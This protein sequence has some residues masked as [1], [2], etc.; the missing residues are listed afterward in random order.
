[1]AFCWLQWWLKKTKLLGAVTNVPSNCDI[2]PRTATYCNTLRH[3]ATHCYIPQHTVIHRN[4]LHHTATHCDTLQHTA[5]QCYILQH[6][7]ALCNAL[8]HTSPICAR[9]CCKKKN[10]KWNTLQPMVTRRNVLHR[11]IIHEHY[12]SLILLPKTTSNCN[13]LQ[14]TATHCNTLHHIAA[15][16]CTVQ[17]VATHELYFVLV[18]SQTHC[19]TLQHTA[20]Y[21]ST[22]G[23]GLGSRP[24]KMYG[25]RLG[26]GVEYHLMSPTPRR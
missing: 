25:E 20:P 19:N 10:L 15:H 12:F 3:T 16:C 6:T 21:C 24:K 14:H 11:A 5:T 18:L 13:T 1:M 8:Q 4:T 23:G 9:F 17:C 7:A 2:L 26:D 22:R